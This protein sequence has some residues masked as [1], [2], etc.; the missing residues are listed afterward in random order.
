LE[1]YYEFGG[2]AISG[3]NKMAYFTPTQQQGIGMPTNGGNKTTHQCSAVY[4]HC[5]T[6]HCQKIYGKFN[7]LMLQSF[8]TFHVE[9]KKNAFRCRRQY[10]EDLCQTPGRN[11][12]GG[13]GVQLSS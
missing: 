10:S 4:P 6:L 7:G 12:H 5:M 8:S 9:R 1:C 2:H 11:N 3:S 13:R